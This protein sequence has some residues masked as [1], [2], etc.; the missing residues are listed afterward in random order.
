MPVF[1]ATFEA[2][3][4]SAAQDLFE[5]IAPADSRVRLLEIDIGQYSDF[6]FTGAALTDFQT[7]ILSLLIIRGHT[8]PGSGGTDPTPNNLSPYSRASTAAIAANNDTVATVAGT[9]VWATQWHIQAGFLWRPMEDLAR[10]PEAYR[11]QIVLKPLQSLVIRCT[12]P[13][14]PITANG[15]ILWEEPGKAPVS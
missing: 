7:E 8:T 1:S 14:D 4:V 10:G 5:L 12:A 2:V 6:G 11:R 13:V 15:S 3:E 9:T